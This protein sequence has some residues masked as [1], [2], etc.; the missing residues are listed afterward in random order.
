MGGGGNPGTAV[1]LLGRI[2]VLNGATAVDLGP[3]GPRSVFAV[4]ALRANTTVTLDELISALWGE[5]PPRTAE[6]GIYSHVS[7]LRKALE[8][9][10]GR[11]DEPR[12]LT[13]SRAGYCLLLPPDSV[14]AFR[15]QTAAAEARRCWTA[16]DFDGALIHCDRALR[17]WGGPPLGGAAGPFAEAERSRLELLELDLA[18]LRCAALLETGATGGAVAAL[19]TLTAQHPLR[20]RLHEL[21]MLALLRTGRPAEAIE[22][23]QRIRERLVEEL[24]VEPGPA[25]RQ[26]HERVRAGEDAEPTAFPLPRVT[27]AQLPHGV[28]EFTGREAE[29]A[30]LGELCAEASGAAHGGSV[31]ISAIDGAAGVGK[32]AL[33]I[34]LAHRV[35]GDF[36]D[37]QL[38]VDLRGFDPHFSPVTPEDA[39]GHLLRGLG[40]QADTQHT[41]LAAQSALYR[42]L[43]AGRRLLV[44]LDNAVSAEQVRPL[45]P[46][47]PGCLALVTSR[48]RLAG[49]V[50]RDGA[51]RLSLDV[52]QPAESLALLRRVLGS[53]RVAVDVEDARALAEFCGHLPLA[54]RIAA[55]RVIGQRGIAHLVEELRAERDRLDALSIL[56]DESSVLRTVFSWS[57][58]S[59]KPEEARAFRLLGLHPSVEFGVT[60]AAVLLD[61]PVPDA[62]RLLAG[63]AQSHLLEPVARDRHRFHDLLRIYAAECAE[64]DEAG[65]AIDQAVRRLARWCLASA[66]AAREVLTPEL[67]PIEL[68]P[69]EHPPFAPNGYEDAQ[70][71]TNRELAALADVLR[72][73][74]DRGLDAYA[75]K[76]ASA[77]GS[78]CH[79]TSRWPEWLRIAEIGLA[80]AER[81]GDRLSVARLHNDAGV[82]HHFLGHGDQA[83]ACHQKAAGLL[84][85]L[86]ELGEGNQ[87]AIAANLAVAYLMMGLRLD[88]LPLL[89]DA[90]AIARR[91]DSLFVEAAVSEALSAVL[92][93]QGR[94]DE[95]IEH[96]LRC[97]AL[98]RQTGSEHMLA[99]G[100]AQI[101]GACRRAGRLDE[102]IKHLD[103]AL[104]LWRGL[105]DR[106]GE[107]HSRHSLARALHEAG[108]PDRARLLLT[109]ALDL[110][111]TS[112]RPAVYEREAGAIRA[113]LATIG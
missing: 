64:R 89:Q 112:G 92:S 56:D 80:A 66:A 51:T 46:A 61:V 113:L 34:H 57:Y 84:T 14:D 38:F 75:A 86:A 73:A 91:Q 103:D 105:G 85:E 5:T 101:G 8:P 28:A 48:N 24:G 77:L 16:N 100:M 99:H 4:L 3:S 49:L 111:R 109:E 23:Y 93:R 29:L 1:R 2:Q 36:P 82:V 32:T 50:A 20:E 88:A 102:A 104:Q 65:V 22:A 40:A 74:V 62:R 67:G 107:V 15:F 110:V 42:S 19:A 26:M 18:E 45:L 47:S 78:L 43:L 70:A 35:S 17:E 30:R 63:L 60:E 90:L 69:P 98:A 10:R 44:V 79:C 97:V 39:L 11:K 41:G 54:L 31:V 37:G 95:A 96:G 13:S 59:L 81:A 6:G 76:L 72:L 55:E 9:G 106:W 68:E 52:L 71:W 94:H 58:Q 33:A 21:L 7:T 108:Q 12:V 83:V 25:L 27:P 53:A 87:E